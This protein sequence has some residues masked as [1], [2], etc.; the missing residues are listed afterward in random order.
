MIAYGRMTKILATIAAAAVALAASGCSMM[1]PRPVT[2]ISEVVNSSKGGNADQ[3][4]ARMQGSKT[5]YALRGSDYGKLADAGVPPP[6][7]DALQQSF[8]NDVDLLT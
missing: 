8:V 3:V 4:I 2:P 6:V 5:T 1:T 7:L